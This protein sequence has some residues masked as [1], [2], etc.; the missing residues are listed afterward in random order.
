MPVVASPPVNPISDTWSLSSLSCVDGQMTDR[1]QY[2]FTGAESA[3]IWTAYLHGKK[4]AVRAIETFSFEEKLFRVSSL[5]YR[6]RVT[7]LTP[8]F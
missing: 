8:R 6:L 5:D 4:V 2:A 1:S 3:D 7:F